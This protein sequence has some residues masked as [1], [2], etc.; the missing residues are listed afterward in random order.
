MLLCGA[1]VGQGEAYLHLKHI[2]RIFFFLSVFSYQRERYYY[3]FQFQQ[4]KNRA[5]RSK[6]TQKSTFFAKLTSVFWP[7]WW[8][9]KSYCRLFKD[10]QQLLRK[11][12][13]IEVLQLII[14]VDICL[15]FDQKHHGYVLVIGG[16]CWC[17]GL[18]SHGHQEDYFFFCGKLCFT[19]I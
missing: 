12:L 1:G 14:G 11:Y 15:S 5:C 19:Q 10:V 6:I 8:S 4:A 17:F 9:K 3:I 16:I 2:L 18:T 7:F 13:G